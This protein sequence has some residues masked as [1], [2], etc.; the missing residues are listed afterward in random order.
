MKINNTYNTW[1]LNRDTVVF[2]TALFPVASLVDI[3]FPKSDSVILTVKY[4][5][6]NKDSSVNINDKIVYLNPHTKAC[7]PYGQD[8]LISFVDSLQKIQGNPSDGTIE[9]PCYVGFIVDED[10]LISKAGMIRKNAQIYV[11]AC[12]NII[13][14][15]PKWKAAIHNG[16]K[17]A[18]FNEIRIKFNVK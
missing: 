4:L 10:G 13:S 1:S 16:R 8:H 9:L 5:I 12:M 11:D 6:D 14:K 15:M 2:Q 18:S 3:D 7:F 17:V